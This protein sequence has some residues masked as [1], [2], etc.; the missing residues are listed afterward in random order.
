METQTQTKFEEILQQTIVARKS[1]EETA[2]NKYNRVRKQLEV[3]QAEFSPVFWKVQN[4]ERLQRNYQAICEMDNGV[5][6]HSFN[7]HNSYDAGIYT[8]LKEIR[9]EV[10]GNIF[11][12]REAIIA[13]RPGVLEYTNSMAAKLRSRTMT[14]SEYNYLMGKSS[15][16]IVKSILK[17]EL[18]GSVARDLKN[19]LEE[20]ARKGK[21]QTELETSKS[22]YGANYP[23]LGEHTE[24]TI[25]ARIEDEQ[26]H[27]RDM[28][29]LH[30]IYLVKNPNFGYNVLEANNGYDNNLDKV[31]Y[32]FTLESAEKK[33][34]E[35]ARE[36][37]N[38]ICAKTGAVKAAISSVSGFVRL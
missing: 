20:L 16:A 12:S 10:E 31:G 28:R 32:A 21:M 15:R 5:S 8:K 7:S 6:E 24:Y 25:H 23:G 18:R 22:T 26:H 13:E 3:A 36:V 37:S 14:E 29:S 17:E 35:R 33:A 19:H 1:A 11:S 4:I 27:L 38:V 34:I 9:E 30:T 2:S